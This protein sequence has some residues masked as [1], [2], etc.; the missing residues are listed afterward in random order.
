MSELARQ[1]QHSYSSGFQTMLFSV[2]G[3]QVSDLEVG[4]GVIELP[5]PMPTKYT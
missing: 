1:L 5:P 2:L 3:F 4:V